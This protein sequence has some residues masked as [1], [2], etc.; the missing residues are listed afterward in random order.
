[1]HKI[2][3]TQG[4]Q[5]SGKTTY[6]KQ[7][8]EKDPV[9]RVRWN[10]DDCRKMCGPYWIPEREN[11]ISEI[12]EKF[13]L[14]AMK[15]G[16]DIVVDDMNLNQKTIAYYND[17]VDYFNLN[18]T[19]TKE[20]AYDLV[21][22]TFFIP[23]EECIKRDSLRPNPIGEKII[24][25]TFNRYKYYMRDLNNAEILYNRIELDKS[26]PN[27]IIVDLDNTLAYAFKRPWFGVEAASQMVLDKVNE[28]L[29][30]ILNS[31]NSNIEIIIMSGRAVGDEAKSSLAWLIQNGIHYNDAY[32]RN[33]NDYRTGDLVKLENYNRYIK[34]KFNV[35]AAVEDDPKCIK[36]YQEQGI[37]VLQ[38]K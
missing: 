23:L 37:F 34:G 1:M 31:F 21:Y 28:Q 32:F 36:M 2:I 30:T 33:E 16:K 10:N 22:K 5:G 27:C 8:V 26:L 35:L 19:K 12:R 13:I 25:E 9:N 29:K 38:P 15:M 18:N 4:I 6:A 17:L 3:L 20:E 14:N 7:W 11:F 24:K